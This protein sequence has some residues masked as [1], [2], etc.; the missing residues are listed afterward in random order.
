MYCPYCASSETRVIDSRLAE[1]GSTIKRRRECTS[2]NERFTTFERLELENIQIKKKDGRLEPYSREKLRQG[3]SRSCEKLAVSTEQIESL[4]NSIEQE[5]RAGT[6]VRSQMIGDLVMER[7]KALNEVAY[8]RFACV[9]RQ[10]KDIQSLKAELKAL[11][12]GKHND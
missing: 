5:V 6:E 7:L 1:E 9:Y 3:I 10:F 8:I 12:R 2:C 4:L 11:G